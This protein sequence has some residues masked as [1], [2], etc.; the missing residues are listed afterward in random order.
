MFFIVSKIKSLILVSGI[1]TFHFFSTR[2]LRLSLWIFNRQYSKSR[3]R[4]AFLITRVS[5]KT[6]EHHS[7]QLERKLTRKKERCIP[8]FSARPTDGSN[9]NRPL[10]LHCL[11]YIFNERAFC[12]PPVGKTEAFVEIITG[13]FLEIVGVFLVCAEQNWS[14]WRNVLWIFKYLY[15]CTNHLGAF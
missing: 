2:N 10:V 7:R 4:S 14:L 6:S 11:F 3:S 5:N 9:E 12:L 13:A 1:S 15:S 8:V